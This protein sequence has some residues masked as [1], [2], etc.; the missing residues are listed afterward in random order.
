[1]NSQPTWWAPR[2]VTS[3]SV[4]GNRALT[5]IPPTRLPIQAC[6]LTRF[7]SIT[8]CV[9]SLTVYSFV[10]LNADTFRSLG[11]LSRRLALD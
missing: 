9:C 10:F 4:R 5:T 2:V 11:V 8:P 1:M 7:L 3:S 6:E